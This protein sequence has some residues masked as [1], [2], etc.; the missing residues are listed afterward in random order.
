[1]CL[2]G[3]RSWLL[4]LGYSF[5]YTL[6]VNLVCLFGIVDMFRVGDLRYPRLKEMGKFEAVLRSHVRYLKDTLA[7]T[8]IC[9]VRARGAM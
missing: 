5:T 8:D 2:T 1:M 6:Y 3:V 7:W 4:G 9:K